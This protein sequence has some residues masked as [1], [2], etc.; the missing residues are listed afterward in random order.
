MVFV[1]G[2]YLS[3]PPGLAHKIGLDVPGAKN[4][5]LIRALI[6]YVRKKFITL[7]QVLMLLQSGKPLNK[8]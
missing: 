1:P 4:F 6:I 8:P 2:A 5:S 3:E 7:A